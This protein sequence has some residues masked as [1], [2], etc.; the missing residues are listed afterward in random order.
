[1]L[2]ENLMESA[3]LNHVD[4]VRLLPCACLKAIHVQLLSSFTACVGCPSGWRCCGKAWR[5]CICWLPG[6]NSCCF[7]VK[8]PACLLANA[9]CWLLKKPLDLILQAAIFIVDKSRHILDI[10]K[11][12][13][14]L[15]QGVLNTAKLALDVVIGVLE[16]IK[17][18]YKVGVKAISALVDFAL[19]KLLNIREMH[20]RVALGTAKGGEFD[21]GVSGVLLGVN[22]N[23]RVKFNILDIWSIIKYFAERA[24]SGLS[25]FIG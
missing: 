22:F 18:T 14:T 8:N 15:A 5:K 12:A 11:V 10:A 7:R 13:L 3:E 16:G 4:Q 9:A 20:F 21:C 19:T 6:W 25:K 24:I 2:E 1:M 23:L 17:I